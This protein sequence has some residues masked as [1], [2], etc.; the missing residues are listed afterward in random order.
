MTKSHGPLFLSLEV[1][2]PVIMSNLSGFSLAPLRQVLA[3]TFT[4]GLKNLSKAT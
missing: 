2:N 4:G 1:Q 3:I